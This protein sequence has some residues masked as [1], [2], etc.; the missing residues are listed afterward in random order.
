[1]IDP[2][3]LLRAAEVGLP[4]AESHPDPFLVCFPMRSEWD[5]LH[6]AAIKTFPEPTVTSNDPVIPD[7]MPGP[8]SALVR[9]AESKGW[10]VA[11]TYS[12]GHEPHATHGTPSAKPK[13]KWAVRMIRGRC[14]ARAVRTGDAWSSFWDWSPEQ[15]MQR[16]PTL[17]AFERVLG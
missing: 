3:T 14:S 16:S 4:A 5:A 9:L 10:T 2:I 13:A 6:P 11:V 8:V 7:T 1:M 17:A 15:F 12:K